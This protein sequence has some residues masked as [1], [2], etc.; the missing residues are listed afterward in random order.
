MVSPDQLF[1]ADDRAAISAAVAA[2]E[3]RTAGEIVPVVARSSGRYERAE[4]L[5]GAIGAALAMTVAWMLFQRLRPSSDWEG[6]P[7]VTLALPLLLA[8][9]A[10]GAVA[11]VLLA[12]A[13]PGLTR[14]FV[15]RRSMTARVLI[16]AH[17]AFESLHVRRTTGATGVI[18]YVSLFEHRVCVWADQ[19]V[20]AVIPESEWQDICDQMTTALRKGRAREGFVTAIGRCGELLGKHFPRAAGDQDELTNELRILD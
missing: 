5:V 18:L 11:G 1:T 16:A 20:S 10:V 17:H 6:H 13:W 9:G 7:E 19:A 8:I 2:A 12:R 14:A 15:S 3:Q 4:D